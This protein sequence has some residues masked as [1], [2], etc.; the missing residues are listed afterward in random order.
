[1]LTLK[2]LMMVLYVIIENKLNIGKNNKSMT[3]IAHGQTEHMVTEN[4]GSKID[5]NTE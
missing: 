5:T 1:M 2:I 4:R 3:E